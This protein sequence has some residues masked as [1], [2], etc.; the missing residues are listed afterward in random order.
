[1]DCIYNGL[2]KPDDIFLMSKGHGCM[3]QYVI[4]EDK[5]ILTRADLDAYCTKDGRLGVH[6]DIGTPGIVAATGSLGHGLGMAVGMAIAERNTDKTIYVVLSD[7]EI[8]EGST[9]EA[10]LM[11][12]SLGLRNIVAVVDYNNLQSLGRTSDTHPTFY[13]LLDKFWAFGWEALEVPGHDWSAIY[14]A[15]INRHGGKP[16]AIV[17]RT[18]KGK[19]VS[20]MEDVPLWHYRSPNKDEY[21]KA[22]SEL[23]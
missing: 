18:T 1:V 10:I 11:A 4:L 7:G 13:P 15:A 19:G 12:S 22:M 6:P 21:Q 9:F 16:L 17:A 20:F 23:G 14:N 2:M 3:I 5:R 8:M